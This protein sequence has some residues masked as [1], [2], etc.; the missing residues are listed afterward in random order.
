MRSIEMIYGPFDQEEVDF[1]IKSLSQDGKAVING[2]QKDLIFNL[3]YKYFGDPVS[4]NF[5]RI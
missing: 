3:F 1:Y 4:I 2:F 5:S